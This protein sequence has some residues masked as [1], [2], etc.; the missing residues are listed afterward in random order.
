MS[1]I[2]TSSRL[3][4]SIKRRAMTPNDQ[5]T[6]SDEDFLDMLNEEMQYFGVQHLLSTYEEYLVEYIDYDLKKD[7]QE[8]EIPSRAIGNKLR[9]VFF[10]DTGGNFYELSRIALED[11]PQFVDYNTGY[12]SYNNSLFYIQNNK[13]ILIDE[14]PFSDKG[15]LRMYFYLKPS[16]LVKESDVATITNFDTSTGLVTVTGF[17]D[18][19]NNLPTLDFVK[20][21]SPNKVVNFNITPTSVNASAKT[22][23][24]DTDDLPSDL[25]NGDYVTIAGESPVPQ[26]PEELHGILAQRVAV[27]SLE[28]LGDFEAM[29][30]AQQRLQMMEQSTLSIIDNRVESANEKVRPNTSA[31]KESVFGNYRFNRK[32]HR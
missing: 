29:K 24:F 25:S 1:T 16:K 7:V 14:V 27:S 22:L 26:L 5:N 6:F 19:F 4:N 32:G 15:K 11:L 8:Y 13:I 31:L 21:K 28:S 9:A 3:I 23:T 12:S 30:I 18:D 10:V 17:Q 20:A 2:L